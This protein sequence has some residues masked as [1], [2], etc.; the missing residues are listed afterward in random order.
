MRAFHAQYISTGTVLTNDACCTRCVTVCEHLGFTA[1][2]IAFLQLS[3]GNHVSIP[4]T[5]LVGADVY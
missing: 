1:D 5:E 3:A 2:C 4:G